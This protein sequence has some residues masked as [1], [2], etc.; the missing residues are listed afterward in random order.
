M[1]KQRQ[2]D[3]WQMKLVQQQREPT[4]SCGRRGAIP[5]LASS[6]GHGGQLPHH[7]LRPHASASAGARETA[8]LVA[9]AEKWREE[10]SQTR[11]LDVSCFRE[12]LDVLGPR[13]R[14]SVEFSW[15][16]HAANWPSCSGIFAPLSARKDEAC[17]TSTHAT[18]IRHLD[19][20]RTSQCL[21]AAASVTVGMTHFRVTRSFPVA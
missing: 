2:T 3:T 8:R 9:R 10:R 12:P 18:D 13:T 11:G 19:F 6:Q 20:H 1:L 4:D 16:G 15:A 5:T 21:V 17:R 7:N 14:R